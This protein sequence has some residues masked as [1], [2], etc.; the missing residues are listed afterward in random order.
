ML[1]SRFGLRASLVIPR[2]TFVSRCQNSLRRAAVTRRTQP[3]R[4][5]SGRTRGPQRIA[6]LGHGKASPAIPRPKNG[7]CPDDRRESGSYC[8]AVATACTPSFRTP[9]ARP[10]AARLPELLREGK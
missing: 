1:L 3:A 4:F 5:R 6:W 10:G 2:Q 8:N 7:W 9:L